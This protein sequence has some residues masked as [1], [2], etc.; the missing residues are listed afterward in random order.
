M[1]ML[2]LLGL[3][4]LMPGVLL[5]L[6]AL[7]MAALITLLLMMGLLLACKWRVYQPGASPPAVLMKAGAVVWSILIC[8]RV[9]ICTR[10]EVNYVYLRRPRIL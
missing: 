4:W 3:P 10:S 2:L 8:M 6:L 7:Q 5:L 9:C 1:T